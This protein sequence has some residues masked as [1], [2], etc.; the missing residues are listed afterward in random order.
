MTTKQTVLMYPGC[1]PDWEIAKIMA[2]AHSKRKYKFNFPPPQARILDHN[3]PELH[4]ME[5]LRVSLG[6]FA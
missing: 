6:D 3:S 5:I 2:K 1:A 4:L